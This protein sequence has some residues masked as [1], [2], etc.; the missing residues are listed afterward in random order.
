MPLGKTG[1][2]VRSGPL[3]LALLSAGG[4]GLWSL[5][6]GLLGQISHNAMLLRSAL[7]GAQAAPGHCHPPLPR[8]GPAW[9]QSG[10]RERTGGSRKPP[11]TL[12]WQMN[13]AF[14]QDRRGRGRME[15]LGTGC[16]HGDPGHWTHAGPRG[17]LPPR[18][19]L[20]PQTSSVRQLGEPGG[21]PTGKGGRGHPKGTW[22][23]SPSVQQGHRSQGTKKTSGSSV[24]Q[25]SPS[26][27]PGRPHL[28][29][30]HQSPLDPGNAEGTFLHGRPSP[31]VDNLEPSPPSRKRC[32][33]R[34][35]L[36]GGAGWGAEEEA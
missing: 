4:R 36:G 11:P 8:V 1:A 12:T 22:L 35:L 28:R 16:S 25:R 34:P 17:G 19:L 7:P 6:W 3:M 20:S 32:R 15:E 2:Q 21:G 9:G 30:G 18:G 24:L 10:Q 13:P 33:R 31:A 23:V 26:Q 29:D 14:T 27:H 5:C